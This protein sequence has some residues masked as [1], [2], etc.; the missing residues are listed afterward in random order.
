MLDKKN[1]NRLREAIRFNKRLEKDLQG[2]FKYQ[3]LGSYNG[4]HIIA[5]EEDLL[6]FVNKKELLSCKTWFRI[7]RTK[8]S[9]MVIPFDNK[10]YD[11]VNIISQCNSHLLNLMQNSRLPASS[12]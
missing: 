2:I 4:L 9:R 3:I 1:M 12:R 11:F 5:A 8:I 10:K 6:K 7:N